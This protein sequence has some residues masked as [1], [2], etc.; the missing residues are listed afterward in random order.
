MLSEQKEEVLKELLGEVTKDVE[1]VRPP[2][3]AHERV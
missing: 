3:R 1:L 2:Q